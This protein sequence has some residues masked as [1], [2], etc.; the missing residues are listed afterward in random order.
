MNVNKAKEV[1]RARYSK[2]W[3]TLS[4]ACTR[5]TMWRL[6]EGIVGDDAYRQKNWMLL[7]LWS[8]KASSGYGSPGAMRNEVD[9]KTHYGP[10]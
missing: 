8:R 5:T 2:G 7:A 3:A 9:G 4:E 10:T 6:N 1:L